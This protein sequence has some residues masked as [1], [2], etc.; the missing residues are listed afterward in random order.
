MTKKNDHNKQPAEWYFDCIMKAV[1][2]PLPE[3]ANTFSKEIAYLNELISYK[4][5][6]EKVLDMGCGFGRPL[7]AIAPCHPT[8]Q[9]IGIDLDERMLIE[10]RNRTGHISNVSILY[11]DA[12]NTAFKDNYFDFVYST[13]NLIG[14]LNEEQREELIREKARLT[15]PTGLIATITW[16]QKKS[17]TDFLRE[18]Y[19]HNNL[20]IKSIDNTKTVFKHGT[21]ERISPIIICNEYRKNSI[22]P[23]CVEGIGD[24]WTAVVGLK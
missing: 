6:H 10:A 11:N 13:Y 21:F 14:S 19:P 8:T 5:F 24:L 4:G 12:L 23:L 7:D 17:T 1:N 22:S 16:N 18:Y 9:F 20:P 3:L 15:M 2:E